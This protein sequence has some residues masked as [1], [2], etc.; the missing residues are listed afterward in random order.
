MTAYYNEFDPYAAQWLRNLIKAKLIAPGD[1]DDRDIRLV[2]P[3]DLRRYT[4][5]HFF[6][7]IGG[8][9]CALRLA[10]WPDEKP[11]WSASLPCQPF[12]VAGKQEGDQDSRHLWPTFHK[13]VS[14]CAP[15]TIIG[16]QSASKVGREWFAGIRFDL[17]AL[18]FAVG[19]ADLCS[20]GVGSPNIRQRLFW[21]GNSDIKRL[22]RRDFG[23]DCPG[24]RTA[25]PT[26]V[27]G[28]PWRQF[29]TVH[30]T[31]G[32]LRRIESGS[33]PLLTRLPKGMG[34]S[35]ACSE[36]FARH[37]QGNR[38]GRIRGYGNAINTHLAAEFIG[39]CMDIIQ[40]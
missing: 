4:Q 27:A 26:G 6:A 17:E 7:G 35:S 25:G 31:N 23:G 18:G 13:L 29:D 8:W 1:V 20:A 39:A 11:I 21:V 15:P 30:F 24:K 22:E 9:S 33:F 12:S 36:S 37:Y 19:A 16:E 5:C 28:N 2:R 10:G 3:D 38:Q 32:K 14:E 34:R 40:I